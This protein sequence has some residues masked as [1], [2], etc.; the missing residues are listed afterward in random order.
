MKPVRFLLPA[1]HEIADAAHY[2]EEQAQG[3]GVDFLD[4]IDSAIQDLSKHP[5]RWPV[6]CHDIR[7]RLIHRFPYGILYRNNS[8]EIVVLAVM[9]MRRHP[10]YWT[11]RL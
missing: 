2:Y 3:L 4:K 1:E 8:D 6:L 10:N 5:E 9:H 11:K 7:R